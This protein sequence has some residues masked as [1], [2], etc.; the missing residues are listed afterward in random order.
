MDEKCIQNIGHILKGETTWKVR[1]EMGGQ[2]ESGSYI[3]GMESCGL[4]S[5]GAG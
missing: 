2:Y 5:Y 3:N 4:D 1:A